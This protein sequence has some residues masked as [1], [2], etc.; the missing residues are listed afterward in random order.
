MQA[1]QVGQT[2]KK[3]DPSDFTHT[4]VLLRECLGLLDVKP[5]GFYVDGTVGGAGHASE[6]LARLGEG[7]RLLGID[8]DQEALEA[9]GRRL[10]AVKTPARFELRHGTFSRI[11]EFC[12]GERPDGILL[13]LGVSSHQLD[14]PERGFSYRFDGPLDMRMDK[15]AGKSAYDIVNGYTQAQLTM[16]IR[17]YGEERYAAKIA[18]AIVRARAREEIRTTLRLSEIVKAAVPASY[19]KGEG[20]PAK[21][22]FQAIRIEVNDELSELRNALGAALEILAPGGRLVVITFHSLE[23]RIVKNKFKEAQNPCTCPP[24]FPVCVCG[25]KPLGRIVTPHPITGS[26]AEL[27]EN[28]R[29]HSAKVRAFERT[30]AQSG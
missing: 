5:D 7:G 8:R 16:I 24:D 26:E 13:D 12:E 20:H 29:A 1:G 18:S 25:K 23:D 11:K 19:L 15:T 27:A 2:E 10:S 17:E 14:E 22:T 6:V 28:N 21:R 9:A 4:P 3:T 30:G